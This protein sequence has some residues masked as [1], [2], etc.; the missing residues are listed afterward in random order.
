MDC[1]LI[2]FLTKRE[3]KFVS[4]HALQALLLQIACMA[5]SALLMGLWFVCIFV[6]IPHAP[7]AKSAPPPIGL[8]VLMATVWLGWIGMWVMIL[9]V[10]IVYAV[11]ASRGQWSEY[12]LLGRL[13]RRILNIGA[14][15]AVI[16]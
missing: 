11:K 6:M 5:L 13:S 4:F 8:F 9:V 10:A 1:P 12:P 16:H 14:G 3:S 15:G 2:I 7:A